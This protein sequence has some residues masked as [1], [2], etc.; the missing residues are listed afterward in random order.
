MSQRDRAEKKVTEKHGRASEWS[1]DDCH[2]DGLCT[3]HS[4]AHRAA[5]KEAKR[6]RRRLDKHIIEEESNGKT[7]N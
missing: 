6:A 7:D 5:S 2:G 4:K 1:H 3:K